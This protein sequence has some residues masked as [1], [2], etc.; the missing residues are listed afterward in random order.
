MFGEFFSHKRTQT[1]IPCQI[2]QMIQSLHGYAWVMFWRIMESHGIPI[3]K[4]LNTLNMTAIIMGKHHSN[5]SS[6]TTPISSFDPSHWLRNAR[7]WLPER[8]NKIGRTARPRFSPPFFYETE[9]LEI[10][11]IFGAHW[12]QEYLSIGDPSMFRIITNFWRVRMNKYEM[13]IIS[14]PIRDTSCFFWISISIQIPKTSW[15]E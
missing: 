9:D 11:V 5:R 12:N 4:Y 1:T 7:L 10:S 3:P 14:R 2:N 6:A 8:V 13:N 15:V